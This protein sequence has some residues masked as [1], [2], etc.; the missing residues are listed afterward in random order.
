MARKKSNDST[1]P[2][3]MPQRLIPLERTE[4]EIVVVNSR[5]IATLAPVSTTEEARAFIVEMREKYF[6]ATHNVPAYIIGHGNSTMAYCSD[7]GEPSG[8]SGR[9][10]LAVLQGSGLGDVA[11]VVTRYFGGT[12][13]GI[14]GLVRAYGDAGKAVLEITKRAELLSATYFQVSIPYSFYDRFKLMAAEDEV[15][16]INET[17]AGEILIEGQILTEIYEDFDLKVFNQT[18]GTVRLQ[19]L[20]QDDRAVFPL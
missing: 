1:Q 7:D 6:D 4:A 13:L 16:I 2:S 14:G 3:D 18:S 20:S 8:S 12:K 11:V 19:L 9:P 10:L 15:V 17:F 5:F